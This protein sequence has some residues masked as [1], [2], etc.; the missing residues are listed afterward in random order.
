MKEVFESTDL[1]RADVGAVRKLIS[2][3]LSTKHCGQIVMPI[4]EVHKSERIGYRI[5]I[6]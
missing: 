5:M 6:L 3:S 1:A 2:L 4:T